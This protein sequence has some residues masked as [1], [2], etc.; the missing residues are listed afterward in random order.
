MLKKWLKI[1]LLIENAIK[2]TDASTTKPNIYIVFIEKLAKKRIQKS[3]KCRRI[4][5]E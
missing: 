1:W 3:I 2:L 4:Q 5:P